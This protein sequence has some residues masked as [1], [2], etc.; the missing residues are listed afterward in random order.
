MKAAMSLHSVTI[1]AR[2]RVYGL[3]SGLWQL[4]P[5]S[6]PGEYVSHMYVE[7]KGNSDVICA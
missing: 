3:E 4:L 7:S 1:C 2:R 5:C 6:L